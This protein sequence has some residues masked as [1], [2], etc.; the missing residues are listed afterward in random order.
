M[1][2]GT[3]A[4]YRVDLGLLLEGAAQRQT[5]AAGPQI[6]RI[7]LRHPYDLDPLRAATGPA[8]SSSQPARLLRG[9][10][11]ARTTS[12]P[13]L[14]ADAGASKSAFKSV[15]G[16]GAQSPPPTCARRRGSEPRGAHTCASAYL[17]A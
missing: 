3:L 7:S 2:T 13:V 10:R 4:C 14:R 1:P 17:W 11:R 9:P 12:K 15:S 16:T 6:V 8:L 5:G